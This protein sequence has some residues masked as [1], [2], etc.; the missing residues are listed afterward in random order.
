MSTIKTVDDHCGYHFPWDPL[1]LITSNNS[2]YHDIHHQ[3]WG[4]KTNFSQP[5]FIFWDRFMGT[6]W[7]GEVEMKYE[8]ARVAAEK[9]VERERL[10]NNGEDIDRVLE[11][12]PGPLD[13]AGEDFAQEKTPFKIIPRATSSASRRAH[14]VNGSI[15]Q[16]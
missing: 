7:E 12:E 6:R 16:K 14:G 8:R 15:R 11:S 9:Q 4:I 2:A 13:A 5:F 10:E 1:Q 3:S